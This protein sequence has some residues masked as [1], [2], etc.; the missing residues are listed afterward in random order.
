MCE[1][2]KHNLPE[3]LEIIALSMQQQGEPAVKEQS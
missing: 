1:S 2:W 3:M